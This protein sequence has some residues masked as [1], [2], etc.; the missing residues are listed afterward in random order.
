MAARFITL[1]PMVKREGKQSVNSF[2]ENWNIGKTGRG[3]NRNGF[4]EEQSAV[5]VAFRATKCRTNKVA[6]LMVCG[7][8]VGF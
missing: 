2:P 1:A 6:V 8:G 5:C 7:T 4:W 3:V